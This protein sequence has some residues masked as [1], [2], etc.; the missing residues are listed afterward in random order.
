MHVLRAFLLPLA[1]IGAVFG[2][3]LSAAASSDDLAPG[4]QAQTDKARRKTG[5]DEARKPGN[6]L[7]GEQQTQALGFARSQHP[8]LADLLEKL[9]DNDPKEY[10]RALQDLFKAQQRLFRLADKAPQRYA[11]ELNLWKV[12]SRIRLVM[13]QMV[14]GEDATQDETLKSLISERR[15]L[16][17]EL[18]QLDRG[19]SAERLANLD[20]QL[21]QM[22]RDPQGDTEK[23]LAKLKQ[24]VGKQAKATKTK[25]DK[26]NPD[27]PVPPVKKPDKNAKARPKDQ[28]KSKK[29]APAK[30]DVPDTDTDK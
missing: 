26:A 28:D 2:L 29:S 20:R 25:R 24:N 21:E 13:A 8:E 22:Q 6:S 12:E 7:T 30:S 27:G 23:E 19:Q 14:M 17:I 16:K 18:L 9:R 1:C 10:G 5:A 4:K 3:A 11:L 15:Q